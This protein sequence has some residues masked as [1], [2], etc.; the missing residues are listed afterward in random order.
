[1][2]KNEAFGLVLII[3]LLFVALGSPSAQELT[4]ED[5]FHNSCIDYQE[6]EVDG[7]VDLF[8]DNDCHQYPYAD[9]NGENQT[10]AV[11]MWVNGQDYYQ[12]YSDFFEYANYSYSNMSLAIGYPGTIED[13]RCDLID[14][15]SAS[16]IKIYDIAFGTSYDNDLQQWYFENCELPGNGLNNGGGKPGEPVE[17]LDPGEEEEEQPTKPGQEEE[18]PEEEETK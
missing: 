14:Q 13:Y 9:G 10:Q 8:F 7:D 1:M 6:N 15:G 5:K 16:F 11:D 4:I 18:P 17:P 3:G 2:A 12:V